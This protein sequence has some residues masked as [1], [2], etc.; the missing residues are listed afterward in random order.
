MPNLVLV[1]KPGAMNKPA[2]SNHAVADAE[3][4]TP[5]DDVLDQAEFVFV[6]GFV[7]VSWLVSLV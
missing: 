4:K 3:A 7:V 6:C 2:A 5:A 1:A